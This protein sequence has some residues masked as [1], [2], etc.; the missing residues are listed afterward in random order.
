MDNSV[1]LGPQAEIATVHNSIA[2]DLSALL[3]ST[4]LSQ[5]KIYLK[6]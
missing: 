5:K 6:R 1:R 2:P 4:M 3:D